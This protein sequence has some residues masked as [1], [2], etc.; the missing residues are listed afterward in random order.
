MKTF[1]EV[2]QSRKT[3][4]EREHPGTSRLRGLLSVEDP[5]S[6]TTLK[7]TRDLKRIQLLCN[8]FTLSLSLT[9]HV[10]I[11]PNRTEVGHSFTSDSNGETLTFWDFSRYR[12]VESTGST[13]NESRLGGRRKS[14]QSH[15]PLCRLFGRSVGCLDTFHFLLTKLGDPNL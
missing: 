12:S 1:P 8:R 7:K 5:R 10:H 4:I 6:V 14:V 15:G 2:L 3:M 9:T 11:T 13:R